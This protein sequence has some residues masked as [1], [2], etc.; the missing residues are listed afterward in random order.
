MAD[1]LLLN[2]SLFTSIS[3]KKLKLYF[4]T[5]DIITHEER[6]LFQYSDEESQMRN[7]LSTIRSSL[8]CG[9]SKP[10]KSF[11]EL[12]EESDDNDLQEKARKLG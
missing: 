1:Y 10:F 11:L 4:V 5:Y 12:L 7:V 9:K 6:R 3:Y 8:Q 2:Q